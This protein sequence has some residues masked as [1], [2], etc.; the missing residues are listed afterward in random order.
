MTDVRAVAWPPLVVA[1]GHVLLLPVVPDGFLAAGPTG[2]RL[3]AGA[4]A[5]MLAVLVGSALRTTRRAVLPLVAATLGLFGLVFAGLVATDRIWPVALLL[6]ATV[7]VIGYGLHRYELVH[8]GQV[9]EA[10]A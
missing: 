7:A 8:T 10:D 1:V 5:A 6:V 3:L 9:R 4:E 2:W